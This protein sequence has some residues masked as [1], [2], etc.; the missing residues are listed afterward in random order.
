MPFGRRPPQKSTA[1][2]SFERLGGLLPGSAATGGGGK[3]KAGLAALAAVGALAFKNRD[4]A[5]ALLDRAR[6][7]HDVEPHEVGPANVSVAPGPPTDPTG[8]RRPEG[9]A[10][11]S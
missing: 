5:A 4:K 3:R 9:D 2:R 7:R 11:A 1:G 6:P 10:A 8:G